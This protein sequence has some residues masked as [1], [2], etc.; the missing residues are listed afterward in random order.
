MVSGTKVNLIHTLDSEIV[1]LE[2]G[3]TNEMIASTWTR[4]VVVPTGNNG[5]NND[6][7]NNKKK[8]IRNTYSY[9]KTAPKPY[10][11]FK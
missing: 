6:Q 11:K 1:Q 7:K 4:C 9:S 8:D 10:L 2:I 5:D 3:E